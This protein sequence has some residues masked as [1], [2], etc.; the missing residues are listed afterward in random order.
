[1]GRKFV[2]VEKE[3]GELGEV[4]MFVNANDSIEGQMTGIQ[5]A[6]KTKNGECDAVILQQ[7]DGSIHSFFIS[8]NLQ[9]GYD[10]QAMIG[11][12]IRVTYLRNEINQKSKRPFKVFKVEM[13][14]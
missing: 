4:M 6:V 5:E 8:S 10:W 13:A 14:A 9:F 7:E 12:Y 1:M 3:A 11:K 2:E